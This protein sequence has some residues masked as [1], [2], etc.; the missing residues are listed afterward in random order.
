M[1]HSTVQ[2]AVSIF[3]ICITTQTNQAGDK[4]AYLESQSVTKKF[5]VNKTVNM[6]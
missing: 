6:I 3:F 5:A 1:I 2:D 4:F